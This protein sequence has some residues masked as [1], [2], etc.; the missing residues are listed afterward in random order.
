[1][2]P[3]K[4][5]VRV[6][7]AVAVMGSPAMA[8]SGGRAA[9][10][11]AISRGTAMGE[12]SQVFPARAFIFSISSAFSATACSRRAAAAELKAAP[13][14]AASSALRACMASRGSATS[15]QCTG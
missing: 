13:A 12:A 14:R 4:W 10:N 5:M 6:R 1:M 3:S 7:S 2:G 15:P 8:M 11:S 9:C